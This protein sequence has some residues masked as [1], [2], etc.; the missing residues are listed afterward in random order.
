MPFGCASEHPPAAS[1]RTTG[2]VRRH[3]PSERRDKSRRSSGG[4]APSA[5]SQA[6]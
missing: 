6:D 2:L 4:V 5:C 3:S 1:S